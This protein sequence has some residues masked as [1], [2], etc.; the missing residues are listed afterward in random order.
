M[1]KVIA[2]IKIFPSEVST[3]LSELKSRIEKKLPKDTS[4]IASK[5]EPIAFG[6][7]AIIAN[8]AMP[9][10]ISGKMDEVEEALK[11]TE[12]VSEIQV[13]NVTRA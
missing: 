12:G 2:S 13:V 6:L 7:V 8:I 9:E 10:E 4:I 1:A 11:S 3:D 5:E